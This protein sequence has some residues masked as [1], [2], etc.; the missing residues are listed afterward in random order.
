M[1]PLPLGASGCTVTGAGCGSGVTPWETGGVTGC[2]A[3]AFPLAEGGTAAAGA[4]AERAPRGME[5]VARF[6]ALVDDWPEAPP[7]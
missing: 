2:G 4:G 7:G 3:A 5:A 6:S 1:P